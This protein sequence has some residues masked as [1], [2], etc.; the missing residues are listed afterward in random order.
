MKPA[1][2]TAY[3]F[4]KKAEEDGFPQTKHKYRDGRMAGM[5]H[6]SVQ[7]WVMISDTEYK[8]AQIW[9]YSLKTSFK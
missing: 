1:L 7:S 6:R 8:A 5:Q 4:V 3:R 2:N 9:Q